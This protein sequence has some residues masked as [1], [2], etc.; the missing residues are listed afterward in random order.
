MNLTTM[1]WNAR[2]VKF[3]IRLAVLLSFLQIAILGQAR[4]V[5]ISGIVRDAESRSAVAEANVVLSALPLTVRTARNGEF[6]IGV[7]HQGAFR[8]AVSHVAYEP[9]Q[10]DLEMGADDISL[11]ISLQQ[12]SI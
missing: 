12:G 4:A 3:P 11:E 5:T 1:S 8:L 10:A 2:T 6:S 9:F 7:P